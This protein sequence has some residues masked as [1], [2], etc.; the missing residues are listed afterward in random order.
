MQI[1]RP[2]GLFHYTSYHLGIKY[3]KPSCVFIIEFIF[4]I[5][6]WKLRNS[7]Y[8]SIFH[9]EIHHRYLGPR[10]PVIQNKKKSKSLKEIQ[11][12]Q[13]LWSLIYQTAKIDFIVPAI[14]LASN[15]YKKPVRIVI[16][17]RIEFKYF[18]VFTN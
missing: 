11:I 4:R 14:T 1:I 9:A 7:N 6:Y 15:M 8:L 12:K 5:K 18:L 3:K 13:E 10:A 16:M 2:R 17:G